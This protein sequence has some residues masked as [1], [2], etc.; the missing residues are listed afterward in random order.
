MWLICIF[1]R[2]SFNFGSLISLGSSC[3]PATRG[4][5]TSP[6]SARSSWVRR[7]MSL[8]RCING[9]SMLFRYHV[10]N[11]CYLRSRNS[12]AWRQR[13]FPQILRLL[14]HILQL[15]PRV[16]LTSLAWSLHFFWRKN[17]KAWMVWLWM[18]SGLIHDRN[19][20]RLKKAFIFSFSPA[21]PFFPLVLCKTVWNEREGRKDGLIISPTMTTQKD[22]QQKLS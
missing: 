18:D 20:L 19:S 5:R 3:V 22:K 16:V 7:L 17:A 2:F 9:E 4:R 10:L 21:C 12:L 6:S 14:M 13:I 1:P 8:Q 11:C 15:L